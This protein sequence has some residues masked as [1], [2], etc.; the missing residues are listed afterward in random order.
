M[1]RKKE[2]KRYVAYCPRCKSI[3]VHPTLMGVIGGAGF[4]CEKCG[5]RGFCPEIDVDKI[6]ELKKLR[7][8][9]KEEEEN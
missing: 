9:N 4:K 8:I 2:K 3:E 5:Y 6:N 7:K 1:F